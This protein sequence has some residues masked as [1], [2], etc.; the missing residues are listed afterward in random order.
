SWGGL[1]GLRARSRGSACLARSVRSRSAER[2]PA[3]RGRAAS[4][5]RRAAQAAHASD[6]FCPTAPETRLNASSACGQAHDEP[7]GR[8]GLGRDVSGGAP[9]EAAREREA[10]ARTVAA[11][12]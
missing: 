1:A 3:A 5:R 10:E 2:R 8:A 12:G 11:V 6:T 9:G 7:A 4:P